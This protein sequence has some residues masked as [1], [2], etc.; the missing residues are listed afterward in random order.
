MRLEES[1]RRELADA[2]VSAFL[3]LM[4]WDLKEYLL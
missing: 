1:G 2:T 3:E 4:M